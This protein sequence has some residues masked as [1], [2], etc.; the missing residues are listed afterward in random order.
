[1]NASQSILLT[2]SELEALTG[3]TQTKRMHD[4]LMARGWVHEPAA[5]RGDTPKVDRH[6]YLG[7]MSTTPEAKK[8]ARVEPRFD[9]VG[10]R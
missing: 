7:R 5:R 3:T 1:M 2:R 10:L 9:L 4:W 8:P 6:Y